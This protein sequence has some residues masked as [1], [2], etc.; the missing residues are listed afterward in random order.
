MKKIMISGASGFIGRNLVE[1]FS[2]KDYIIFSPTHSELSLED[3]KEVDSYFKNNDID[4]IV[5]AAVKPYHRAVKETENLLDINI[6]MHFNLVKQIELKRAK[7]LF[8]TGTG[9][10]YSIDNYKPNMTEEYFGE[11]IP[12]DEG[13]FSR[14]VCA[15]HIEN[16]NLPIYNLRIFGI[17]G[18][19]ENYEIRFVSNAICKLLYDMPITLRQN[20]V[21]S[22]LYV[23]D[24]CD[25]LEKFFEAKPKHYTYNITPNETHSLLDIAHLVADVAGK[26]HHPINVGKQGKGYEYS[27]LNKRLLTEFKDIKFTHI[28]DSVLRMIEYYKANLELVDKDKLLFDK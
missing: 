4:I 9:S 8:I 24:F 23:D 28:K 5:H 7:K 19:Y 11:H 12:K 20:R 15:K 22:Y 27:G 3:E 21:F 1:Y 10:E 14:Y 2:K 18:K 26:P 17:F 6:R 25:I 13:T 16:S